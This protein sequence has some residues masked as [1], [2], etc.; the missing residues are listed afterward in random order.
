MEIHLRR[1]IASFLT[2]LA[3][4]LALSACDGKETAISTGDSARPV[5]TLVI[6]A[7]DNT[8]Q[9]IYPGRADAANRAILSFRVAGKID[10]ILVKEGEEVGSGQTLAKLDPRDFQIEVDNRAAGYQRAEADFSRAK[11]LVDKGHLSRTDYDRLEAEYKSAQAALEQ[12]KNNLSY[13]V[14]KA[15][16]AGTISRRLV[17]TFE[18]V[19]AKQAV[20]DL[21]DLENL[22]IKFDVPERMV[23]R[24]KQQTIAEFQNASVNHVRASFAG[25]PGKKFDLNFKEAAAQADANTQ[26][27]EVTFTMPSPKDLQVLPG[28]T[29]DVEVDLFGLVDEGETRYLVP[30]N[31]VVA[32]GRLNPRVWLV[33]SQTMILK[34]RDV[35]VGKMRG[36]DIEVLDGI[37]P[38]D[39]IV[40]AGV[41]YM[42]E[43][44]KVTLMPTPEQARPR[45]NEPTR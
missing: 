7:P 9:R 2:L 21:R 8:G 30:A 6:Q 32:D 35:T 34:S 13:T 43:G 3:S 38:G 33:D 20:F 26:T 29:A 45:P 39:R 1:T 12:A 18:Q 24:I 31:A 23:Q 42:V 4:A 37:V 17:E 22:E 41:A 10:E 5:K 40:V 19:N 14:L 36:Q 15:P 44:M 25:L 16:F 11:G 28:M 27:F